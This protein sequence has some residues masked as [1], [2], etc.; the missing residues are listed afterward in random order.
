MIVEPDCHDLYL[1]GIPTNGTF[2][3]SVEPDQI[4]APDKKE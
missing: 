2:P 1:V 4:S 3:S